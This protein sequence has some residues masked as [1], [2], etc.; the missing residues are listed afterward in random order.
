MLAPGLSEAMVRF[1]IR[2]E[3]ALTVADVLSRRSRLLF[4]D[5]RSAHDL[6]PRVASIIQ[7][8]LGCDPQLE[9]FRRLARQY[10]D[11]P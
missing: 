11:L 3:Y 2:H 10:L 1:A 9:A 5:A 8:E 7:T 4:L 6:A